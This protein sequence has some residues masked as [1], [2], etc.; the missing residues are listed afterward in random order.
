MRILIILS[1]AYTVY[2][3]T[4]KGEKT[5]TVTKKLPSLEKFCGPTVSAI[6]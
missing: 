6:I 3:K 4:V 5:F 2:G 1:N